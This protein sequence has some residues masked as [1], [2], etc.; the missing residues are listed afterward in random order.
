MTG[1][2]RTA[3]EEL[4][5]LMVGEDPLRIEQ[6]LAKLRA[7]A[8]DL[9]GLGGIFTLRAVGD[10]SCAVGHQ[11]QGGWS[12]RCGSCSAASG[13]GADICFRVAAARADR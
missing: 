9:C 7:V 12:S 13:S 2:L 6:T 3:V 1:S 5:A 11:G 10:R 4:G 8:G